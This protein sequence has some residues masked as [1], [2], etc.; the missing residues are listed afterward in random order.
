MRRRVRLTLSGIVQGVGFRPFLHRLAAEQGLTGWCRNTRDGLEAELQGEAEVLAA[1]PALLEQQR[2]PRSLLRTLTLSEAEP[3]A[4]ERGFAI[5]DSGRP[6]QGRALVSPDIALCTDCRRELF[7]PADRR[8]RHPFLNCTNC[9]PRF[10][11]LRQLPYDR[12]NTAMGVFPMCPACQQ[13]Y[14]DIA[15]R[16]YHA[17]PNCCPACGPGLRFLTPSGEGA[18]D[19]VDAACALLE[20]GGI[21]AVKGLGGYHLA[22]RWDLPE[23]LAL[24][25]R[26]KQRD[27][28]PFALMARDTAA[29]GTLCRISREEAR[30]LESPAAPIVLLEKRPDCPPGLSETGELGVMLAYTPLHHL[31]MERFPLLVMTSMNR[32]DQP[33][34]ITSRGWQALADGLLDHDRAIV[35]RCDDSLLRLREGRPLFFRRSRGYAPA[36]LELD[37]DVSG[38]LA[39]GAEEKGSFALGRGR[40]AFLSQHLGDLKDFDTEQFY[41]GQ[42]AR[43]QDLFGVEVRTLVCDLHPDYRSSAYALQRQAEE[44]LAL[45]R[46]Q[47]HHAH[48][49]AC[50]ADNGLTGT[51]IGLIWD[52]TGLGTDGTIWGSECLAGGREGFSRLGTIAPIPL[53]GG[54]RCIREIGRTAHSLRMLAGAE[55][56]S[57]Q[58]RL[59]GEMVRQGLNSPL[60]SGMGRLLDGVYSLL[61]GRDRITYPGQGA[62]LLEA[63][64]A[65]G[66]SGG[67]PLPLEQ[68]EDLLRLDTGALIRALLADREEPARRAARVWNTLVRFGVAQARYARKRTGLNRV[69]LSG[70]VFQNRYLLPRLRDGLEAAGFQVYT[71]R[72]VSPNDQGIALGQLWIAGKQ[73]E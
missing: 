48:L 22:C 10:T 49:A 70:G 57:P 42:I 25:R 12:G 17:Q 24:L 23:T 69:V 27:E 51:C 31:L 28:R 41:T 35:N 62:V 39:L 65:E 11:I 30:W 53:P 29:A 20:Q 7:S 26:R 66:V 54:D 47:H 72:R 56:D 71:H 45:L 14:R 59:L 44:G 55:A 33:C 4:G 15:D 46:V 61:T 2:P 64:A 43:F 18:G 37:R 63:M 50:M 6:G 21:V 36:P 9:G 16:R 19:P 40:S 1:L 38:I 13:E 5:L 52:G 32:S 60:S 73:G 58:A 68:R 3:V 67:Y 8:F 34:Q